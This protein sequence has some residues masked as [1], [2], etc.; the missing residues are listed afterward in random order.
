MSFIIFVR[1]CTF[2]YPEL[3][4]FDWLILSFSILSTNVCFKYIVLI[5]KGFVCHCFIFNIINLETVWK[6]I[7]QNRWIV[8]FAIT[9]NFSRRC[10]LEPSEIFLYR[11]GPEFQNN[12]LAIA[13]LNIQ[14]LRALCACSWSFIQNVDSSFMSIENSYPCSYKQSINNIVV[15]TTVQLNLTK[16]ELRFCAGS[17]TAYIRMMVTSD[18]CPGWKKG[19]MPLASQPFCKNNSS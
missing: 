2:Y 7:L 8:F 18:N 12:N 9:K 14:F 16:S 10:Q 6:C 4:A 11:E 19:L 1:K 17:N 13:E 15:I 5:L 3:Y